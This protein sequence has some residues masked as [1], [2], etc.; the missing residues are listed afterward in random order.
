M[1]RSV[2]NRRNHAV[3]WSSDRSSD[4][5]R[6][7][8]EVRCYRNGVIAVLSIRRIFGRLGINLYFFLPNKERFLLFDDREG[9]G[10]AQSVFWD[11]MDAASGSPP[12]NS[13]TLMLSVEILEKCFSTLTLAWF[14]ILNGVT[15]IIQNGLESPSIK[16]FSTPTLSEKSREIFFT[17]TLAKFV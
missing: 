3:K 11:I 2:L 4:R 9:L 15:L 14:V 12:K 5:R 16:K 7:V 6:G 8:I 17:L 10:E 13:L 1:E